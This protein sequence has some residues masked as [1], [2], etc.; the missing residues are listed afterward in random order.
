MPAPSDLFKRGLRGRVYGQCCSLLAV[1]SSIEAFLNPTDVLL[2]SHAS[3]TPRAAE[4]SRCP[5]LN[6]TPTRPMST[7]SSRTV[8]GTASL[9]HVGGW[10]GPEACPF[11]AGCRIFSAPSGRPLPLQ[12]LD[13]QSAGLE[14]VSGPGFAPALA[15]RVAAGTATSRSQS[16][17][18]SKPGPSQKHSV[19]PIGTPART[20]HSTSAIRNSKASSFARRYRA[21]RMRSR[22]AS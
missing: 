20:S 17:G 8:W 14:N 7:S 13:C 11:R 12:G 22:R 21:A 3:R 18:R 4:I 5:P 19:L 9:P 16:K 15:T 6:G 1:R 10:V 2:A